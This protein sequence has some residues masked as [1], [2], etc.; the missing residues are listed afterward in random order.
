MAIWVCDT[1]KD[2]NECQNASFKDWAQGDAKDCWAQKYDFLANDQEP[3]LESHKARANLL[4]EI[5][6]HL[7]TDIFKCWN[8]SRA[9]HGRMVQPEEP[10]CV[11]THYN[12][13]NNKLF[14]TLHKELEKE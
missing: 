4:W 3:W 8:Q 12:R 11:D 13:I 6:G 14:S 7:Y 5:H 9:N 1:Y 10:D 2:G